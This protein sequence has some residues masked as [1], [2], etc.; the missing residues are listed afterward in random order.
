MERQSFFNQVGNQFMKIIL[1]SPLHGLLSGGIVLITVTG[2]KSGK[3]Y[4]TPVN[5]LRQG[6]VL[7]IVSLRNR[8]WWRNLRG[9]SL[10]SLRLLGQDV[11]GWGT[12]IEDNQGVTAGLSAHLQQVPHYAKY[13]GVTLDSR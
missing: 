5:Y 10:V 4:T 6:D 3:A 9:G 2:R 13:F 7:R 8:T 12:V 11:K 1:R